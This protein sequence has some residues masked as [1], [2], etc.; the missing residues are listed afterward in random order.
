MQNLTGALNSDDT[1][2]FNDGSS[3][4]GIIDG[5]GNTATGD[6][7][8]LTAVQNDISI[9]TGE[10]FTNIEHVDANGNFVNTLVGS[11]STNIWNINNTD[12]GT[13]NSLLAFSGFANLSGND[14]GN[15][16]SVDQFT[17][18]INGQLSG[19][20][21]GAGGASDT[22][23]VVALNAVDVFL[24]N[25]NTAIDPD[26]VF[27]INVETINASTNNSFTKR[28]NG[29]H[30]NNTW[31]IDGI[32]TGTIN[33]TG[34]NAADQKTRFNNFNNILGGYRDDRFQFKTVNQ[35]VGSISG[36]IDANE[37]DDINIP[38]NDQID[39]SLQ[40][41]AKTI[42]LAD[43]SPFG[44]VK[45]I[46]GIIGNGI[47]MTL[48]GDNIVNTWDVTG[49]NSGVLNDAL[50]DD[51]ITFSGFNYLRGNNQTD[52]FNVTLNPLDATEN[53]TIGTINNNIIEGE[54]FG[55][56]GD[57]ILNIVLTGSESGQIRFNGGGQ[58]DQVNIS[59]GTLISGSYSETYT[60]DVDYTFDNVTNSYDQ[61]S[62]SHTSQ[63]NF[64]VDYR[65]VS[66]VQDT[67]VAEIFTINGTSGNDSIDLA[68]G[69]FQVNANIAVD[70]S[71]LDK[72]NITVDGLTAGTDSVTIIDNIGSAGLNL[73][74]AN[75]A[76]TA[77]NNIVT[78]DNLTF[79]NASAGISDA[80]PLF[81]DINTLSV[82]GSEAVYI[83]DAGNGT[84]LDI[85]NLN[86][87]NV[88]DVYLANGDI[89]NSSSNN[90]VS[91]AAFLAN[92]ANGNISILGQNE[93]SGPVTLLAAN[94]TV[95]FENNVAT[96][97][98]NVDTNSFILNVFGGNNTT[99]TAT[100]LINANTLRLESSGD[101]DLSND[102]NIFTDITVVNANNVKISN[103]QRSNI[104][105]VNA[106][107][108]VDMSSNGILLGSINADS[109][110]LDAGDSTITDAPNT[111]AVNLTATFVSL[112]A[113]GGIG[114][115]GNAIDTRINGAIDSEGA[116]EPDELIAINKDGGDISISNV[117]N[118]ILR[119][120][121]NLDNNGNILI[122]NNGALTID[123]IET[124]TAYTDTGTGRIDIRVTNGHIYASPKTDYINQSDLR[125]HSVEFLLDNQNGIGTGNRPLSVE[126]PDTVRVLLSTRNYISFYGTKPLNF[127]GEN[128]FS[129]LIFDLISNIAGQQLIEVESLA[130]LDPAIF[131][132]VRN[133]S[134][135]DN[136]LMMPVDQRYDDLEDEKEKRL[137]V[138]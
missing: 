91:S 22:L 3:L 61:I 23:D 125:A 49:I 90:L 14:S 96:V 116:I 103:S 102:S 113:T 83:N 50:V 57:D 105:S 104:I 131:T 74:F 15:I 46:E 35:I 132:D 70:F 101:F 28:I 112:T 27:A 39:Y 42:S 32:N 4:A 119:N 86:T 47:N 64:K 128:E 69:Y 21:D 88:V 97:L 65:Q 48:E 138:N 60:P 76:V 5:R 89:T 115:I 30:V 19:Y 135:S 10:D 82:T 95:R 100:G 93:L 98:D 52:I 87:T 126:V 24:S 41:D 109:I 58:N 11:T 136:A 120:I 106:V 133:Y 55:A 77:A 75:I 81:T 54:I 36:L 134:H 2:T 62:Y 117:G 20:I 51:R 68:A 13:L 34:N 18:S 26:Y 8:D 29:G 72:E 25:V 114:T 44:S 45:N 118:V 59:S 53:G 37:T 33:I 129:N 124:L 31:V 63:T 137:Q 1:F 9:V 6:S 7:I 73:T 107:A 110:I 122:N 127:E 12:S 108:N 17:F 38:D 80:Q 85:A 130:Q 40:I 94:G 84:A 16:P 71:Y 56:G 121:S 78:A 79:S 43:G 67:V 92:A 111:N 123:T 66:S 99:Q